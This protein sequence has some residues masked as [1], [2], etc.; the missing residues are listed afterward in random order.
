MILVPLPAVAPVAPV[1][2]T[3][4][5]NVAPAGTDVSA[6]PVCA[7][8]QIVWLDGVAV[9][10]G[11]GLTV[12]VAVTGDPIQLP[13]V[14]V[15]VYVAVPA[16]VPGAV[17]VCAMLVPFPA[18]APVTPVCV[19]V[20]ANV[21]P[22]GTDVS[23]MFGAVPEQIVC[24]AGVAVAT[25]VGSTVMVT[26]I[27]APEQFPSVGVIVYVAVPDVVPLVVSVCAMLVPFP[28]AAPATPVCATVH[29]NVAPAG[30]DVSAMPVCVPEQIVCAAGV[31]VTV[32]VGSTVMVAV[33]GDP[34]HEPSV[35]VM[36]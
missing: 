2:A 8:E 29:A 16:A 32:G 28:A 17:S 4:H 21:D 12:T 19:T 26:V 5:A 23:A 30:T 35:G 27:G 31:A 1:S 7:P 10:T 6:M 14:G 36:L 22:V 20:H 15:M 18:D 33:T 9:T 24:V 34:W 13:R 11:V 3:V 25:G